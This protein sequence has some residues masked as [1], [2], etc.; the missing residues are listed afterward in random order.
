MVSIE[1][2]PN[3]GPLQLALLAL[4]LPAIELIRDDL[5]QHTQEADVTVVQGRLGGAAE[6]AERAVQGSVPEPDRCTDVSADAG[7]AR[8]REIGRPLVCCGVMN[9]MRQLPLS[10][11][12]AVG[13]IGWDA[14]PDLEVEPLVGTVDR[15]HDEL[16]VECAHERHVHVERS[17]CKRED[18][19]DRRARAIGAEPCELGEPF[20]AW[21]RLR[22]D[23]AAHQAVLASL[24]TSR[25]TAGLR[26]TSRIVSMSLSAGVSL[27]RHRSAPAASAWRAISGERAAVTMTTREPGETFRTR[28]VASIP[29]MLGMWTS[30]STTSGRSTSASETASTPLDAMTLVEDELLLSLPFAPRHPEAQCPAA[31]AQAAASGEE[32]ARDTPS[33]FAR[34]AALKK[35]SG[36]TSKE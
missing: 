28:L 14:R 11:T 26:G 24:E 2:R 8:H 21:R 20:E 34:L 10:H 19:L 3:A 29:S 6:A 22:G 23:D 25:A 9:E 31:P 17:P 12:P 1:D 4:E 13:L 27:V 32:H 7:L 5:G 36:E 15:L 33:P 18:A 30:I 16:A 35:G